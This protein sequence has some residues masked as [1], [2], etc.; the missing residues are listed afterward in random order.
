[1]SKCAP[2]EGTSSGS[3]KWSGPLEVEAKMWLVDW[4]RGGQQ[5]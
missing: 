3:V 4:L 2:A 1:M 5:T